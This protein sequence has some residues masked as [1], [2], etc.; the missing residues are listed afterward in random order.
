MSFALD[1]LS[2][3]LRLV[4]D[5]RGGG[6]S[7]VISALDSAMGESGFAERLEGV[8]ERD[9][10]SCTSVTGAFMNLRIAPDGYSP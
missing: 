3:T 4:S 5:A 7:I 1:E 9:C 2:S 8:A 6:I 10:T